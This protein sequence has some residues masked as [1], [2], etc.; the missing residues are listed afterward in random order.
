MPNHDR[1]EA[2]S[3]AGTAGGHRYRHLRG[4]VGGLLL[5]LTLYLTGWLHAGQDSFF[6]VMGAFL[7]FAV[8]WLVSSVVSF[9]A[10]EP[11]PVP[12]TE[13]RRG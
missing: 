5:W 1:A 2:N 11:T 12:M 8:G 4:G 3:V 9:G 13:G 7:F 6:A 10:D